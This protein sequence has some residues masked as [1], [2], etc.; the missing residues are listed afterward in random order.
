MSLIDCPE[1]Q[2]EISEQA[3]S[4]PNCGYPIPVKKTKYEL[5]CERQSTRNAG[6]NAFF[7]AAI[8][9]LILLGVIIFVLIAIGSFILRLTF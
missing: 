6:I 5:E 9:L 3:K 7:G 1:C 4:C 2:K 8:G